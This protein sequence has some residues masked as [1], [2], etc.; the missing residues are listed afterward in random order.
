MHGYFSTYLKCKVC[1]FGSLLS[2]LSYGG[3]KTSQKLTVHTDIAVDFT[4]TLR[5]SGFHCL[6]DV[7]SSRYVFNKP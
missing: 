4:R 3:S 6:P 7:H 1:T 5:H 2:T